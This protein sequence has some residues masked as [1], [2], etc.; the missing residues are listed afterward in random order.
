M[1]PEWMKPIWCDPV[2]S[3]VIAQGILRAASIFAAVLVAAGLL[4]YHYRNGGTPLWVSAVLVGIILALGLSLAL[5]LLS[6]RPSPDGA[7][8][9]PIKITYPRPEEIL[10]GSQP[11]GRWR[12]FPVQGTLKSKPQDHE[13]WL[14]I[15]DDNGAVWPQFNPAIFEAGS[16]TWSGW[17][18]P[19]ERAE[20]RIIAVVAP[21]D[22]HDFFRYFQSLGQLRE[23]KY[24]PL[25]RVPLGCTNQDTVRAKV[26]P[27]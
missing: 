16:G 2:W 14:L 6:R 10:S 13:V 15:R 7:T 5:A 17:I 27:A 26:P 8:L 22:L 4:L 11:V 12:R 23:H 20:V 25:D 24:V 18:N 3:K 9:D 1:I 21:P 19:A